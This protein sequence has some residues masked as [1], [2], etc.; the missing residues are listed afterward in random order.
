[1]RE[2]IQ[3]TTIERPHITASVGVDGLRP[4]GLRL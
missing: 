1:M 2:V 3:R 4:T